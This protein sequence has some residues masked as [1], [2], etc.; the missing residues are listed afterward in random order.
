M[1]KKVPASYPRLK[2]MV[3][4]EAEQK[5]GTKVSMPAMK[6]G[7]FGGQHPGKETQEEILKAMHKTRSKIAN[8][9]FVLNGP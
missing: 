4:S 8:M 6:T 1:Q 9:E 5:T 7:P 3:R 2:E